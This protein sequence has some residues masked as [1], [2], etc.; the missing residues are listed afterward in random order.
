MDTNVG[1]ARAVALATGRVQAL[2]EAAGREAE[3]QGLAT[4]EEAILVAVAELGALGKV[5]RR[6]GVTRGAVQAWIRTDPERIRPLIA[7]A[8]RQAADLL[9]EEAG[10][11]LN[12]VQADP[13]SA[14][15][16]L[17]NSKSNY[18]RWLAGVY[19]EQYRDRKGGD[20]SVKVTVGQLH[21]EA[22]QAHGVRRAPV[23]EVS[24][25]ED[26]S[27]AVDVEPEEVW[28]DDS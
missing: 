18:M 27:D 11:V 1:T 14:Q 22:L 7:E 21:L 4:G 16:S 17:A 19:D 10:D 23:V 3:A 13:T 2:L 20:V 8:R 26:P 28:D 25:E 9:A 12:G 6:F 15:V 24:V 5:A